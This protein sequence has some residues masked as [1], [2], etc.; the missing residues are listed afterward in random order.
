[1]PATSRESTK[2]TTSSDSQEEFPLDED[3]QEYMA[4]QQAQ[5][6]TNNR[7]VPVT[8]E[9]WSLN[10]DDTK[11]LVSFRPDPNAEALTEEMK[12]PQ[13]PAQETKFSRL[14]NACGLP[15]DDAQL[16]EGRDTY[17]QYNDYND[18]WELKPATPSLT[19][20]LRAFKG[21]YREY[22]R[23][24]KFRFTLET[25]CAL[26]L[27]TG[28]GVSIV[29]LSSLGLIAQARGDDFLKLPGN[30]FGGIFVLGMVT[31]T[32]V[33]YALIAMQIV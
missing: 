27:G 7:L 20:K 19:D 33:L 17:A 1:M 30:V 22:D 24:D 28:L 13:P 9:E 3:M 16:L 26:M 31:R 4:V 15:F 18:T 21:D 5:G 14:V 12:F 11:A 29:L 32:L 2:H 8:I 23:F 10:T 25:V 6:T